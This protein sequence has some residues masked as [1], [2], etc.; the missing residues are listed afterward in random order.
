MNACN[1]SSN[2]VRFDLL[3]KNGSGFDLVVFRRSSPR[4]KQVLHQNSYQIF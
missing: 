3:I 4:Y 1:S 2:K